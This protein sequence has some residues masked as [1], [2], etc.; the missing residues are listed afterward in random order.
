MAVLG[1]SPSAFYDYRGAVLLLFT[2]EESRTPPPHPLEVFSRQQSHRV[3]APIT[4]GESL[5]LLREQLKD[6]AD[7]LQNRVLLHPWDKDSVVEVAKNWREILRDEVTFR[8]PHAE[9]LSFEIGDDLN[10]FLPFVDQERMLWESV[11]TLIGS[12][13]S[14]YRLNQLDEARTL[15]EYVVG[16]ATKSRTYGVGVN[17]L[18]DIGW[19]LLVL[20]KRDSLEAV[21]RDVEGNS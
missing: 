11:H 20:A 4:T 18:C 17:A 8:A 6:Y 16:E 1:H 9:Y 10:T 12:E 19:R 21:L 13:A 2:T 3:V 5:N 14:E 7:L 15:G